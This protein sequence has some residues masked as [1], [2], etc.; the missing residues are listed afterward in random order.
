MIPSRR[1]ILFG[2]AVI[3]VLGGACSSTQLR[4]N[5]VAEGV[6]VISNVDGTVVG[7]AQVWEESSG[8]V[9]VEIASL[10]LPPG[11]HGIHFHEVGRCDGG[12]TAFS[13]AGAHYNPTGREHGLDNPRG[14]HA[15]DAPNIVTPAAGFGRVAFSTDRVRLSPGASTLFDADGSAIV[16]HANPDDQVSQP[17]GNSGGRI[18]CGVLR[19]IP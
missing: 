10:A 6:A 2:T 14:A 19:A 13:T 18:A 3:V 12:S 9:H 8:V 11:T 5:A 4:R 15:G 1:S 16:V 7:T 17:A